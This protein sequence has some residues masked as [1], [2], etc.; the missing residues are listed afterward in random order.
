MKKVAHLAVRYLNF[1]ETFIYEQI[2]LMKQFEPVVL[3]M[4]T[5]NLDKFP[6]KSIFSISSLPP[7]QQQAEG[8]RSI[9][10][11]S[12]YFRD[13]IKQMDIKLIHAHFAYMG[14]YALQFK[15]WF[16]IPIISSFYG[17][18]IYQLTK[19]PLYRM[20]LK[21]LFKNADH[22][23]GYSSV[24]RERA[25]ELGCPPEKISVLTIGVDF[26]KFKFKKRVPTHQINI[27]YIGRL[28]EKKG[29]IYGIRAFARSFAKHK[30]IK[31]TLIGDGPLYNDIENE[32]KKLGMQDHIKMLGYVQDTSAELDKAHIFMSPSVVARS[33]DAEG[34]INVTVIEA[35]ASGIPALVTRQT[36]SDL[37]FDGQTG[38]VARERDDEDLSN[39][40]NILIESPELISKFG[41]IGR[42]MVEKLD[43]SQ[44]VEKLENIYKGL[45]NKYEA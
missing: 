9:F 19:N 43:S 7:L 32:I 28:V 18:D 15:K 2:R 17:L 22:F 36:Q 25:I 24:M 8:L 44:Q 29:V 14:N 45:I 4:G 40:L 21:R 39:K 33:G 11:Q 37:I 10:G 3:T 26:N 12:K 20:Q 38:F 41:I 27:L 13:V 35:L 31:M 23:T 5:K 30:N 1:S 6:T 16:N 42:E 34:G